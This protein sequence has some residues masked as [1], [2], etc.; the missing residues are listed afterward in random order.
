M[1]LRKEGVSTERWNFAG[2]ATEILREGMVTDM[3]RVLR[4]VKR[5]H[6]AGGERDSKPPPSRLRVRGVAAA[7][8]DRDGDER[9]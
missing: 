7:G 8:D 3:L 5:Q 2:V 1:I 6:A 9:E 4:C